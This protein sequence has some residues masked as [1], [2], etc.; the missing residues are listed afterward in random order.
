MTEPRFK[1][2]FSGEIREGFDGVTARQRLSTLY[3]ANPKQIERLFT[4]KRMV[5][6]SGLTREEAERFRRVFNETGAACEV[7][8]ENL[9]P[10]AAPV[11]PLGDTG[12]APSPTRR[13]STN[14]PPRSPQSPYAGKAEPERKRTHPLIWVL[15]VMA[16]MGMLYF[17]MF[18]LSTR[19][20]RKAVS[21]A[22]VQTLPDYSGTWVTYNDPSGYYSIDLPQGFSVNPDY[23]GN[24]SRIRFQYVEG[25]TLIID[26]APRTDSWDTDQALQRHLILLRQGRE[27]PYSGAVVTRTTPIQLAAAEGYSLDLK[28]GAMQ[29][30]IIVLVNAANTGFRFDITAR[31]KKGESM[32]ESLTRAVLE[33][34]TMR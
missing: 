3:K 4:G 34:L 18:H 9:E 16:F 21:S 26:A 8:P 28:K 17:I 22:S 7:L 30:R 33:R 19:G 27:A 6:K 5:L 14:L 24:R 31:D 11:K 2:V 1:V 12:P 13:P 29:A 10:S 15:V 23:A 20:M 32:L 25:V